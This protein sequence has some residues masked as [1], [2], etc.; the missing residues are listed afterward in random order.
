MKKLFV[1]ATAALTLAACTKTV[2]NDTK[3]QA[4]SFQVANYVPQTKA[5]ETAF[6]TS[7]TFSTSAWFHP[8]SGEA[9]PFMTSETVKWQSSSKTWSP[10]RIY[11]WPKTGYINFYSW[12]GTP[13]ATLTDGVA[14]YGD[15]AADPVSYVT[16]ATDN[17]AMLASAA[18]R[19]ASANYD[20]NVYS[21]ILYE[22]TD[23]HGVPTLFHHMLSKVTFI[24]KFD[25]SGIAGSAEEKAK[26]KW[27]L[28]INSA[29]LNYA[30]KGA[31]TVTFTDPTTTGQAW[32]Y[33]AGNVNWTAKTSDNTTLDVTDNLG[34]A[35]KQTTVGGQT[36]AGKTLLDEIT[37]LPQAFATT[38]PKFAIN[39]TLK[40]IY[41]GVDQIFETVDLTGANA[42]ALTAF[43]GSNSAWNMN[44]KYTYTVTIKPNHTVTFDPAVEPWV[45][46]NTGNYTY[47]TDL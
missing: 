7:E 20:D 1:I 24:V 5:G 33:S 43:D 27:E 41:N 16:I 19:Y 39:Y 13:A 12:S 32:P 4:I 28:T 29:S 37:V 44:Y 23:V 34:D 15:L 17:D 30:D 14:K 9:Q 8:T 40:H 26:N 21:G 6:S 18:Y 36:S 38:A 2:V 22:S 47:P 11:F 46:D 45:D 42:L 10:D 3:D 25:A 35:N 31:V